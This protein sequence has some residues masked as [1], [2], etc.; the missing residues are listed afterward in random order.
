MQFLK[1]FKRLIKGNIDGRNWNL[2]K[3]VYIVNKIL[4]LRNCWTRMGIWN[5]THFSCSPTFKL[6]RTFRSSCCIIQKLS[7]A[8]RIFLTFRS[9]NVNINVFVPFLMLISRSWLVLD[10]FKPLY[11]YF[12]SILFWSGSSDPVHEKRIQIQ[13]RICFYLKKV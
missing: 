8:S 1:Q 12:G 11:Q 2:N 7:T 5:C 6:N 13:W 9:F 4:F 3:N 10:Y